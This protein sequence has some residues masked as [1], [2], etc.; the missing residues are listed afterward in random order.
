MVDRHHPPLGGAPNEPENPRRYEPHAHQ[1]P[2]VSLNQVNDKHLRD[3]LAYSSNQSRNTLHEFA[4]AHGMET[5]TSDTQLL[6]VD[7]VGQPTVS[8]DAALAPEEPAPAPMADPMTTSRP[9][10]MTGLIPRVPNSQGARRFGTVNLD[11]PSGVGGYSSSQPV[12]A[13]TTTL[14]TVGRSTGG[15]WGVRT[16]RSFVRS[17]KGNPGAPRG[18]ARIAQRQFA[19]KTRR[20]EKAAREAFYREKEHAR[21]TLNYTLRLAE[22]MFHYGADAMDVD[23]AIIAVSSAF[24]LDSVEVDIT[25]QSVTINYTS[26]PDIYMESRTIK[27]KGGDERFTH[28]LVRVVRSSTQN[29]EAL[30]AIYRLI[31]EITAGGI[32]LERAES[33]LSEITNRPKPYPPILIWLANIFTATTLTVALGGSWATGI[34]SAIIFTP[35]YLLMQWLSKI[36]MPAFFS[37]AASSG[38]MTFLAILLGNENS[39]LYTKVAPVSAPVVVAAGLIMFLPT[40][41]LVSAVQDAI[42]GFPVTAAGRFVSTGMSF[43]GL[44]VGIASAVSFLAVIRG[45]LLDVDQMKF[46]PP[47]PIIFS[48]F[49]LAAT[50]AIAITTQTKIQN[51][52]SLMLI[53][54][55]GLFVYQSYWFIGGEGTGRANTALAAFTI[56]MLS[57]YMA[58]KMHAPQAIFSIPAITFLLPGLSFFRGMYA[59]TVETNVLIGIQSM[60]SAVSGILAMAAGVVLGNYLMQYLLQR[61]AASSAQQQRQR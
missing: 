16:L 17:G 47:N 43:L 12:S 50:A 53:T 57:T 8:I 46:A 6:P 26:D 52:G 21:D 34:A 20:E 5:N 25:N 27:H 32:T 54:I 56:G 49:I 28:T 3:A 60:V 41:R 4:Q 18:I 61:F 37:M 35:I 1:I 9:V 51:L 10:P 15:R 33:R 30:A 29:F 31:H 48:I 59:L 39:V 19:L 38:L 45:P 23:S 7:D 11:D 24:G 36:G 14:P 22:A 55:A 58:Y 40:Q 13:P 44:V 42:N 2:A